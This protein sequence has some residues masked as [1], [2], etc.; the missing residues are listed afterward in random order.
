M[1]CSLPA[2]SS[3]LALSAHF[4]ESDR[5]LVIF[6]SLSP[7]LRRQFE[8]IKMNLVDGRS[9]VLI[10]PTGQTNGSRRCAFQSVDG[11]QSVQLSETPSRSGFTMSS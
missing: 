6:V 7:T 10:W 1:E 8:R 4:A 9:H 5:V 11:I 3:S 2:G